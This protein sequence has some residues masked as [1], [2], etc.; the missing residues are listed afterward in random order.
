MLWLFI[1]LAVKKR[2][3][4]QAEGTQ[5]Y[6]PEFIYIERERSKYVL[7]TYTHIYVFYV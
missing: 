5:L 1:Y 7:Y 4:L 2:L 6:F 3:I